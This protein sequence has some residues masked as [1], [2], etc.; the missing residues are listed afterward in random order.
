MISKRLILSSLPAMAAAVFFMAR[1]AGG[2]IRGRQQGRY[3]QQRC[4]ADTLQ[5]LRRVPPAE[6]RGAVLAFDLQGR[7]P[8]G[9]LNSG[10]GPHSRDAS[11][12]CRSTL[13][14]FQKRR[15]SE[16]ERYRH[17]SNLG[18]SGRARRRSKT[19]APIPDYIDGWRIGTPDQVFSMSEEHTIEPGATDDY[20]V[21]TITTKFKE[22]KWIQ[23]A[24]IRP[25]NRKLV[26]HAIAHILTPQTI[27]R[28]RRGGGEPSPKTEDELPIFYKQGSLLRVKMDA[29]VIDDGARAIN[30]GSLIKPRTSDQRLRICS[31]SC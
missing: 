16:P 25:S 8:L 10:E 19:S 2:S 22:D 28:S 13:R 20:F 27:A 9:A 24:E 15:S 29:P 31:A 21:F 6:R 4:R 26:H 5:E 3:I 7:P 11:V 17:Y 30:G 12:A 18:G 23:A 1:A 14:Q